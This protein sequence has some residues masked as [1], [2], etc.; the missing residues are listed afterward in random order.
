LSKEPAEPL[1][2]KSISAVPPVRSAV[3]ELF[4]IPDDLVGD[5]PVDELVKLGLALDEEL[6]EL[7]VAEELDTLGVGL[8]G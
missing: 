4:G 5:V 1:L 7:E 3:A 6:E 2:A 8:L